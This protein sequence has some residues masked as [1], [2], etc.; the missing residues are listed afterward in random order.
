ML[1]CVILLTSV[2][3]KLLD[4]G[5]SGNDASSGDSTP[6][7]ERNDVPAPYENEGIDENTN[8]PKNGSI[9]EKNDVEAKIEEQAKALE[10]LKIEQKHSAKQIEAHFNLL[11]DLV[12]K[13]HHVSKLDTRAV[14]EMAVRGYCNADAKIQSLQYALEN[15]FSI[16]NTRLDAQGSFRKG[17]STS[18]SLEDL[19]DAN[20][21]NFKM[22]IGLLHNKDLTSDEVNKVYDLFLQMLIENVHEINTVYTMLLGKQIDRI[23]AKLVDQAI[24]HAGV[25][26]VQAILD[27]YAKE[28]FSLTNKSA[29]WNSV[30]MSRKSSDYSFK[31]GIDNLSHSIRSLEAKVDRL[32]AES[33]N[34]DKSTRWT[35]SSRLLQTNQLW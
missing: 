26:D 22:A 28:K 31:Q 21:S 20:N 13:V 32:S 27:E 33:R 11:S 35:I 23:H 16:L 12:T 24:C 8:F 5:S 6:T 7:I 34:L 30:I 19:V 1:F 14:E 15:A 3:W 17:N 18:V 4:G 25:E 2:I 10:A 29:L 9:K